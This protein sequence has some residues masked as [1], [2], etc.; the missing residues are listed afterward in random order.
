MPWIIDD[1]EDKMQ[2]ALGDDSLTSLYISNLKCKSLVANEFLDALCCYDM[3]EHGI[4]MLT[5]ERFFKLGEPILEEP[6]TEEVV[7][8]LAEI[9]P[10]LSH[11]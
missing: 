1:L 4:D 2:T 6:I 11:L 10:R 5:L 7:S 9:C 3:P 8:R